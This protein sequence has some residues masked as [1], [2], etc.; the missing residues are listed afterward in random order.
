[1]YGSCFSIHSASLCLLVGVFYPF[2]FKV[3]IDTYVPIT[4]LLIGVDF[5]DPFSSLVFLDYISLFKICC[6]AGLVVLN[7]VNFC[8]SE[9][10]LISPSVLS[11]M[12]T[13]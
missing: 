7:S 11:E 9:K 4:I 2:T 8:L 3:I 13:R 12:L 6:K 10:L 5:V 1:M